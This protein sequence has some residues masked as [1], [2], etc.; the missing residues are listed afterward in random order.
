MF[1]RTDSTTFAGAISGGG[2]VTLT[3]G[4]TVA[5]TA[6]NTYTGGTTIGSGSTLQLGA[7]GTAAASWGNVSDDGTLVFDRSD[8]PTFGGVI[9]GSGGV[10]QNGSG[11]VTLTAGVD[12]HRRHDGQ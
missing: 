6:T 9:S 4:G 11:T 3:A 2:A 10:A 12:V 8:T 1:N 5:L 7:G